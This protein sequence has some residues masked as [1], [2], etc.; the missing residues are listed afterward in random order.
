MD[1]VQKLLRAGCPVNFQ[2]EVR[3]VRR[4]V[5]VTVAQTFVCSQD[6]LTALIAAAFNGRDDVL[7]GLIAA[8]ADLNLASGVSD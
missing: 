1:V 3:A 8:G 6:G 2:R 4:G 7:K 5:Q